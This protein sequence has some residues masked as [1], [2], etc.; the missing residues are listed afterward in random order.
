MRMLSVHHNVTALTCLDLNNHLTGKNNP[1]KNSLLLTIEHMDS[2]GKLGE[3]E[4]VEQK[5]LNLKKELR[6]DKKRKLSK[7]VDFNVLRRLSS[8]LSS[9]TSEESSFS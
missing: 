3:N 1:K 5:E 4:L 7:K 2:K 9:I 8:Q 6:D